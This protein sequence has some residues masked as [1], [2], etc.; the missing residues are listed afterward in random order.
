MLSQQFVK[1]SNKNLN[2]LFSL[3]NAD[4]IY[5]V[6]GRMEMSL[7][8]IDKHPELELDGVK[9]FLNTYYLVT[10]NVLS[11]A[12]ARADS[13]ENYKMVEKLDIEFA[14]LFFT[15]LKAA[16]EGK[17]IPSPWKE[18]FKASKQIDV[19]PFVKM[20]LGINAHINGDLGVALYKV[21]Y[22][23]INDFRMINN[24][25]AEVIPDVMKTPVRE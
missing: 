17:K 12:L 18:Y 25:L 15:P 20:L 22:R 10:R 8:Y 16:V 1:L 23:S 7:Q 9:P 19:L 4:D 6:I 3:K 13:F 24:I 11:E 5:D 14:Q 21:R 2:N